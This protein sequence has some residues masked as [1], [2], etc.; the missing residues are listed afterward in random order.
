MMFNQFKPVFYKSTENSR[1][2]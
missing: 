2:M 1:L